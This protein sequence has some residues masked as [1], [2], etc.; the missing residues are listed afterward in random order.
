MRAPT[1]A[2]ADRGSEVLIRHA[3]GGDARSAD[4]GGRS[5]NVSEERRLKKIQH[6]PCLVGG[7]LAAAAA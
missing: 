5:H 7:C 3:S 2:A 1:R 4:R 6:W